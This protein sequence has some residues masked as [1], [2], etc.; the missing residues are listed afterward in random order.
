MAYEIKG[1][2]KHIGELQTFPSGFAKRE[3]VISPP[4]DKFPQLIKLEMLKEKA[5]VL[6]TV[7]VGDEVTAKFDLQGREYN[8][9][10]F[11]S[12]ICWQL[13]VDQGG[14]V[15]SYNVPDDT[16][17]ADDDLGNAPF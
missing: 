3:F 2:V 13:T 4:A 16:V 11:T 5:D 12:L 9:K 6:Q 14:Y 15:E 1:T 8:G 7:Q 10:Y 17:D